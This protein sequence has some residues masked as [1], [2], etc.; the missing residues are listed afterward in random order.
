MAKTAISFHQFQWREATI[1]KC[2]RKCTKMEVDTPE[3]EEGKCR[4]WY[5]WAWKMLGICLLNV[6]QEV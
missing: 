4:C 6:Q 5:Q 2:G 3:H 1:N